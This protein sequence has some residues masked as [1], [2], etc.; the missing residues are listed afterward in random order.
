MALSGAVLFANLG[1]S[2][3]CGDFEFTPWG[4]PRPRRNAI[5]GT[6]HG[7]AGRGRGGSGGGSRSYR[8]NAL[9][10]ILVSGPAFFQF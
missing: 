9:I 4:T 2:A 8:I 3:S 7:N 10:R 1:L 6:G 5:D